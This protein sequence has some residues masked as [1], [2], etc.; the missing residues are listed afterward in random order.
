MDAPQQSRLGTILVTGAT[1]DIG[2]DLVTDLRAR[3][4]PLRVMCRRQEQL[5]RFAEQ[6]VDGVLGDFREPPSLAAAL[7]GCEQL[8]LLAPS[9]QDQLAGDVAA[10]DAARAAGTT[11][12]VKLSTLDANPASAVPWARDHGRAEAHL[13]RSGLRWST[14]NPGAYMK[15]LLTEAGAVRRGLL[16]QT[17]GHGATT[18]VDTPDIAAAAA[19]VLTDPARHGGTGDDGNRYVLT[20]TPATSYPQIA[21]MMSEVLG[22]RVRYVHVPAPLMFL[23][24]RANGL[25]HW[26]ARGLVHQ[27]VD[28]VRRGHDD[29]RLS[30]P[31][32]AEL[33]GRTPTSLPEY[34]TAHREELVG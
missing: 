13:R 10:I 1:G 23:G 22:Q 9:G 2:R 18:W 32:L 4:V 15:N 21:E 29:G 31:D 19:V 20:G 17:S 33:L 5:D 6:G 16:P 8:F 26:E 11:H 3:G 7:D 25:P 24:L 12:V 34:L 28:V 30:T 27:F 14:L